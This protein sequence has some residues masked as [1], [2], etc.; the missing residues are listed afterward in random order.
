MSDD[1]GLIDA[2]ETE[3]KKWLMKAPEA[4]KENAI[5]KCEECEKLNFLVTELKE[6][7]EAEKRA[8]DEAI[9]M[10]EKLEHVR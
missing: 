10:V 9:R 1:E 8:M 3:R 6:Q 2:E 4:I 7:L 5:P